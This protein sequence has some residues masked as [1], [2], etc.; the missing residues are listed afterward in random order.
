M[1][2]IVKGR[3]ISAST[4]NAMISGIRGGARVTGNVGAGIGDTRGQSLVK[5]QPIALAEGCT[6]F[7]SRNTMDLFEVVEL[8]FTEDALD[9][10]Y[11]PSC[12]VVSRTGTSRVGITQAPAHPNDVIPVCISGISLVK[13]STAIGE[14]ERAAVVQGSHI[15]HPCDGGNLRSLAYGFF[16]GQYYA[17]VEVGCDRLDSVYFQA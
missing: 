11:L 16:D 15:A 13:T 6:L 9:F 8:R 7:C 3:R 12:G 17:L 10:D 14:G 5:V 1:K 4:L 2:E